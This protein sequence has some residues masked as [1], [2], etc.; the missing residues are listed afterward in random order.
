MTRRLIALLVFCGLLGGCRF[1]FD[2]ALGTG[3]LRGQFVRLETNGQ[4]LPA[5]G[6]KVT[7]M[8]TRLSV[9]TDANGRFSLHGLPLASYSLQAAYQVSADGKSGSG[10]VLPHVA[11]DDNGGGSLDLGVVVLQRLAA[12][13]GV[14]QVDG[15]PVA[16]ASVTLPGVGVQVTDSKGAYLFQ[17]LF[18]VGST[19]PA[20][21][22]RVTALVV[23]LDGTV[24]G[25]SSFLLTAGKTT[26][27]NI[28]IDKSA[29]VVPPASVSGLV[30]RVADDT[31]SGMPNVRLVGPDGVDAS[32]PTPTSVSGVYVFAGVNAGTYT[33]IVT[34]AGYQ[35]LTYPFVVV[36]GQAVSLPD[37]VLTK[38]DAQCGLGDGATTATNPNGVGDACNTP[39]VLVVTQATLTNG[40]FD[41]AVD[42]MLTVTLSKPLDLATV[43][44][45]TVL[46]TAADG[47]SVPGAVTARGPVVTF[48]PLQPLA[49]LTSYVLDL[50]TGLRAQDGA[51]L[52]ADDRIPFTTLAD[53]AFHVVSSNPATGM[54]HVPLNATL[55]V[56]FST[57]IDP[58][59]V[60]TLT[61][62]LTAGDGSFVAGTP[63]AVGATLTFAPTQPLTPSTQYTLTISGTLKALNGLMLTQSVSITFTTLGNQ[64][65]QLTSSAPMDG[66]L[67]APVDGGIALYFTDAVALSVDPSSLVVMDASGAMVPGVIQPAGSMLVFTP[68]AG[69]LTAG[70]TYTVTLMA[71][72]V[73]LAG[74]PLTGK[75]SITFRTGTPLSL[76]SSTPTDGQRN[77]AV[78][79]NITAV[80][81]AGFDLRSVTAANVL[82]TAGATQTPVP[83][84]LSTGQATQGS[85]I[86][87]T[88]IGPLT[89]NTTYS[90]TFTTAPMM[91]ATFVPSLPDGSVGIPVRSAITGT[92][93][94]LMDEATINAQSVTVSNLVVAVSAST[95]GTQTVLTVNGVLKYGVQY[96]VTL[97]TS[98]L[99]SAGQPIFSTPYSWTFTIAPQPPAVM[100]AAGAAHSCMVLQDHAL[101][102]FGANDSIQLANA[103]PSTGALLPVLLNSMAWTRV[104]T[105]ARHTC[106]TDD[107]SQ[108]WCWGAGSS[109][110][111]GAGT[112][113]H[114]LPTQLP[115]TWSSITAG[116][117][118][119]CGI[120]SD[121][122]NA[123]SL[124][125]WGDNL[126]GQLGSS[127]ALAPLSKPTQVGTGTNW[128]S[129]SAG[130]SHTCG[131]KSDQSLW[132]WGDGSSGQLGDPGN[133]T[134]STTPL[135]VT[136][137]GWSQVSAGDSH[138]CG[139]LL[140]GT[141]QCWGSNDVGQ[142][143]VLLPQGATQTNTPTTVSRPTTGATYVSVSAGLGHTCAIDSKQGLS[144]W[145]DNSQG[146]LGDGTQAP[147]LAP[148]SIGAALWSSVSAGA[149]HTCGVDALTGM[150]SCWGANT[151]GLNGNGYGGSLSAYPAP[152]VSAT[153]SWAQLA[154][155][156]D[157]T[158][159]IKSDGS[160]WCWGLNVHGELGLGTIASADLPARVGLQTDW[161]SISLGS[162][163][164]CGLR[165][166]SGGPT[167][168][169]CWGDNTNR[170][171]AASGSISI[172]APMQLG[173]DT[174]FASV[175]VGFANVTCATTKRG[176][177]RCWGL[178]ANGQ[179]ANGSVS[180]ARLD[181]SLASTPAGAQP[182]AAVAVGTAH[183]CF[184]DNTGAMQCAG[185]NYDGEL[186][187]GIFTTIAS[188][189][190]QYSLPTLASVSGSY[191]VSSLS[192]GGFHSCAVT[193]AGHLICWGKNSDG[194]VGNGTRTSVD[195]PADVGASGGWTSVS[196]GGAH[197]CALNGTALWCW[198]ANDSAQLGNPKL[199]SGALD[200]IQTSPQLIDNSGAWSSVHAGGSH[201]CALQAAGSLW[202]WGGQSDGQLGLGHVWETTPVPVLAR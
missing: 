170:Q 15:M 80:F 143:G 51:A 179:L 34:S 74:A 30:K 151:A 57:A 122:I 100:V 89:P 26:T 93:P 199:P 154:T 136:G 69:A 67:N 43:T 158:C 36:A 155:G 50:T 167:T 86:T 95:V 161:L 66:D 32:S 19:D 96:T 16:G 63:A 183:T 35:T 73:S 144:C 187:Q 68:S 85:T 24:A 7:L 54:S 156:A 3:E 13:D 59:S 27:V 102:C 112:A 108:L 82:L 162:N 40:Q 193:T 90:L 4:M 137:T 126:Y 55:S 8:G 194:A 31:A 184:V 121:G 146:E 129:V 12:L 2:R 188:T 9:T 77:V 56:L 114:F 44:S 118:H 180:T 6:T 39:D 97:S 172:L 10:L 29:M 178:N 124:W 78:T 131:L 84:S 20:D 123:G 104:A 38:A 153:A 138:T 165:G 60:S 171:V 116:A 81:S 157:H 75:R 174:D 1:S 119:T 168:L 139:V 110:Q 127:S 173:T 181:Y 41:V 148:R 176:T 91:A 48:M 197:S 18:P 45:Q 37:I 99:T 186:G 53:P 70:T 175:A 149:Q 42:A 200:S 145:G 72:F 101:W 87:V 22:P 160:L 111:I 79:T 117:S 191:A 14:V 192:A 201:T 132:C 190:N 133:S 142:L 28:K 61:V 125:C 58:V 105:G 196:A 150:P 64:G 47:A 202:C 115:G 185:D 198:G 109:G 71:S 166:T 135:Q 134:A 182:W 17:G 106:A 83:C 113:A 98:I 52:A 21:Q 159:A 92:F 128:V 164:T 177:A 65:F 140:D 33:V 163:T 189:L 141:I 23:S 103:A 11:L 152:V 25:T 76:L 195:A 130:G 62:R 94:Q 147:A 49:Y 169:W 120:R 107:Q 5:A 88:P 46:L